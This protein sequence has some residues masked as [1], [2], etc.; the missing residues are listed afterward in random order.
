MLLA[1]TH[2]YGRQKV[3]TCVVGSEKGHK[4]A[5][6][7]PSGEFNPAANRNWQ[8]SVRSMYLTVIPY[9]WSPE[10]GALRY[11]PQVQCKLYIYITLL[12]AQYWLLVAF[13]HTYTHL[14][15]ETGQDESQR[16]SL[17]ADQRRRPTLASRS[18]LLLFEAK[19]GACRGRN[20][21]HLTD[22]A[23]EISY[24]K[25]SNSCKLL[26]PSYKGYSRQCIV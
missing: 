3:I 10:P 18:A 11:Q 20:L 6:R 1:P 2:V 15:G 14:N 9:W 23:I 16:Q 22:L 4:L 7:V 19:N 8:R 25:V 13:L 12:G 26:G 24:R 21:R 17:L 5:N